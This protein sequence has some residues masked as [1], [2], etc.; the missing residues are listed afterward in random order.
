MRFYRHVVQADLDAVDGL[1][2]ELVKT[3]ENAYRNVQSAFANEMALLC[4]DL[5]L[6][7]GGYASW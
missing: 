1:T 6:T 4:E 7:C 3:M 2:A 5:G